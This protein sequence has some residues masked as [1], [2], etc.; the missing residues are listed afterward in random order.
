M[1]VEDSVSH[2][3]NKMLLK[4]QVL[5]NGS[6]GTIKTLIERTFTNRRQWILDNAFLLEEIT[7]EYPHLTKSGYVSVIFK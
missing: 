3:R 7:S 5:K 4:Q 1:E 6:R 2:D